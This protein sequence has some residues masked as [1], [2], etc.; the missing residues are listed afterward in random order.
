MKKFFVGLM[1]LTFLLIAVAAFAQS[2]GMPGGNTGQMSSEQQQFLQETKALR[3]QKHTIRCEL[4]AASQTATPDQQ[5]IAGLKN[6]LA[7][8]KGQIQA[9]AKELGVTPGSGNC[10]GGNCG[11]NKPLNCSGVMQQ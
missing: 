9:K 3:Q 7:A 2:Q 1:E 6:E 10:V 8:V 5:K 11:R 4:Q